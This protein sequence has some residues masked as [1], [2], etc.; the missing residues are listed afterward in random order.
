[1]SK[2]KSEFYFKIHE[3]EK[4]VIAICD[5]DLV[6][7]TFEEGDLQLKVSES[8]YKG[9]LADEDE[10]LDIIKKAKNFNIVGNNIVDLFIKNKIINEEHILF[11]NKI[12]HAQIFEI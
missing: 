4:A 11:I 3:K 6:G 1:M 8:F 12:L 5:S 7:K 2:K 9:D 10:I